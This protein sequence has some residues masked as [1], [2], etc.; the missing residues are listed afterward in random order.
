M[1][2]KLENTYF[3]KIEDGNREG[4]AEK[5]FSTYIRIF[6][7]LQ[8]FSTRC[9]ANCLA[10]AHLINKSYLNNKQLHITQYNYLRNSYSFI[11]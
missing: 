1:Q 2:E 4:T 7:R 8:M 6:N 5:N 10:L 3:Y 11:N 9:K